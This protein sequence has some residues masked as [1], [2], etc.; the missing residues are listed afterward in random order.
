M[1]VFACGHRL[2]A[3]LAAP[4]LGVDSITTIYGV[5]ASV[6]VVDTSILFLFVLCRRLEA[7]DDFVGALCVQLRWWM[8]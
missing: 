7:G 3:V 1:L 4:R 5:C 2:S 8:C 6:C